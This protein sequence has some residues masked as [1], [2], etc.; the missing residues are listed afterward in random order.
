MKKQMVISIVAVVMMFVG[1]YNSYAEMRGYKGNPGDVKEGLP[2]MPPMRHAGM[3]MIEGEAEYPVWQHLMSLGLDEKQREAIKEI[4]SKVM[5]EM[6]KKNADGHIAGIEL[7]DLLDKDIVDMKAVEAKL[8]QIETLKTEMQLS[9]IRAAE[10]AK[11][12]LTPEQRKKFKEMR[13]IAPDMGPPM[14]WGMVHGDM[15]MPPPHRG[16]EDEMQPEMRQR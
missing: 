7:I 4:K 2:M 6:I 1:A 5:K 16:K 3:G 8:K 15:R 12:K 10:E 13:E 9:L 11:S 14:M